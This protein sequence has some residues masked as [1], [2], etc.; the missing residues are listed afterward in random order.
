MELSTRQGS[1]VEIDALLAAGSLVLRKVID[2]TLWLT[3]G[4]VRPPNLQTV[5]LAPSLIRNKRVYTQLL[6]VRLL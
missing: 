5:H 4:G 1:G 3:L 2:S 6:F